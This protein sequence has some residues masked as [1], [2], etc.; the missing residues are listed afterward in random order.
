MVL[1]CVQLQ[2][3]CQGILEANLEG[4][5]TASNTLSSPSLFGVHASGVQSVVC[6]TAGA[7]Q[8]TIVPLEA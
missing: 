2:L 1:Y 5:A 8:A 3:C 7:A 6:L 4:D